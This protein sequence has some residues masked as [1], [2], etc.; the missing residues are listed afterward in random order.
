MDEILKKYF[1]NP[2]VDEYTLKLQGR[3]PWSRRR[4]K[5]YIIHEKGE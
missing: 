3:R 5:L 2:V 1:K 4:V